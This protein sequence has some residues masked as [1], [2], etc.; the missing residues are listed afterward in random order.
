MLIPCVKRVPWV[1]T[2]A[3]DNRTHDP[4]VLTDMERTDIQEHLEDL[5]YA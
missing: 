4:E 1:T 5:G 3:E 2:D